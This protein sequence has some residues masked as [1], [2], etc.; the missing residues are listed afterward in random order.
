MIRR[1]ISEVHNKLYQIV[2]VDECNALL[3][4]ALA[5]VHVGVRHNSISIGQAS[6]HIEEAAAWSTACVSQAA[7][8]Q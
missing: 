8:S 2:A 3:P 6:I 7:T 5:D 4:V 1:E